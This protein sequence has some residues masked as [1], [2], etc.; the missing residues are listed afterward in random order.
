M[1]IQFSFAE[2]LLIPCIA[3]YV[4]G[5]LVTGSDV[6]VIVKAKEYVKTLI[7]DMGK[8][9]CFF[10][11]IEIA[12]NKQGVV[13]FQRK[14]ALNLLQ[15]TGLLGCKPVSTLMDT[16]TDLWDETRPLFENV[17]QY[18][19]LVNL[20]ISQLLDQILPTLLDQ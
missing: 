9:R 7:Q 5:V 3:V 8:P 17:S 1:I 14:Y 4:D 16:D 18:M 13:L 20:S 15:E 11:R 12:R 19:R 10:Y 2:L 6:A